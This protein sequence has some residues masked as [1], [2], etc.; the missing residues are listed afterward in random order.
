VITINVEHQPK[1]LVIHDGNYSDCAVGQEAQLA[2]EFY[3]DPS[4]TISECRDPVSVTYLVD[5]KYE[6]VAEVVL[7]SKELTI[8]DIGVLIYQERGSEFLALKAGTRIRTT[9]SLGVDP[10]FYFERLAKI[11]RVPPLIYS[12]KIRSILRQTA[13]YV[14]VLREPG[15]PAP[16]ARMAVWPDTS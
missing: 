11:V 8:L 14:E 7:Q 10:F 9:P 4:D 2:T 12:W 5:S 15:Q 1:R 13:P 16:V 3:K 6:V